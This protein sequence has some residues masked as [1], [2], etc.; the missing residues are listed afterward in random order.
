MFLHIDIGVVTGDFWVETVASGIVSA[1][2]VSGGD[3]GDGRSVLSDVRAGH[4]PYCQLPP[5]AGEIGHI[6]AVMVLE[7][8]LLQALNVLLEAP[9]NGGHLPL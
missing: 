8:Q 6:L 3:A 5:V 9:Q 7:Y 4:L 2:G 1:N